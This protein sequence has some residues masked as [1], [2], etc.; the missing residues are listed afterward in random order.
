MGLDMYLLAVPKIEIANGI[1]VRTEE[2]HIT[3]NHEDNMERLFQLNHFIHYNV[4]DPDQL[5]GYP[6]ILPY[7]EKNNN[8]LSIMKIVEYWR[9]AVAIHLWFQVN[10]L[11]GKDSHEGKVV[12]KNDIKH[13]L[14]DLVIFLEM[15]KI[16]IGEINAERNSN[17]LFFGENFDQRYLSELDFAQ[18]QLKKIL[19]LFDFNQYH[20]VYL[21]C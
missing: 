9:E 18:L 5:M 21:T 12:M 3:I 16:K 17:G 14:E 8:C 11:N 10:V 1:T 13:L 2:A 19:K 4:S 6:D 7:I 15:N 20:L